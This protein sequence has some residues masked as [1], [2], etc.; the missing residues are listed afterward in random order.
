MNAPDITVN[1]LT[2]IHKLR[3]HKVEPD[4]IFISE[5]I[6]GKLRDAAK[7]CKQ[8]NS[9]QRRKARRKYA[10]MVWLREMLKIS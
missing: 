1:I 10:R 8:G 9:H 7:L 6:Y 4:T 2:A 3:V 5:R